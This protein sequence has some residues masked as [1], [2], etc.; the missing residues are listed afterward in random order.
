[1]LIARVAKKIKSRVGQMIANL[2]ST[3]WLHG[4]HLEWQL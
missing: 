4:A 1:M 3:C 2:S